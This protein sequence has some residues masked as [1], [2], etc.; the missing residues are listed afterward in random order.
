MFFEQFRQL[1]FHPFFN[2]YHPVLITVSASVYMLVFAVNI[3]EQGFY[4]H[5][6]TGVAK[7]VKTSPVTVS[8]ETMGLTFN[9]LIN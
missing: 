7:V 4:F 2:G 6:D 5:I 3:F 9:R 8:S 1:F